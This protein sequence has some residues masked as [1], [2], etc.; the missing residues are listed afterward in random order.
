[1]NGQECVALQ[2]MTNLQ[3]PERR[4]I[5]GEQLLP[6]DTMSAEGGAEHT[7]TCRTQKA[8]TSRAINDIRATLREASHKTHQ[9]TSQLDG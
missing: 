2:R 7:C 4:I 9:T 5:E 6:S 8:R 1:M 3:R